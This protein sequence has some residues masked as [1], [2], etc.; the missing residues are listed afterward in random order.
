MKDRRY[1]PEG[2]RINTPENGYYTSSADGL[3]KART[4]G[5]ILEGTAL[6]CS[7]RDMSL[8]VD[9]GGSYGV[10]P[11]DEAGRGEGGIPVRDIAVITRVAHT[12]CFKVAALPGEA[13]PYAILSRRAAQDECEE[14]Y[15]SRLAPGD[16]IPAAVT[17][18]EPFGA[19][20]DVGC[21]VV[22]L[23]T[24]DTVSVSRIASPADRFSVGD[25]VSAVVRSRDPE[26]G[27]IFLTH[28]ELLGTWEENA[29]E[30]KPSATV[31]GIVRSVEDYG[32]FVEL[33]PNLAGLA[34]YKEGVAPGDPCAVFIK[35]I[36]PEKMKVKLV[37]V[38]C[39]GGE[40]RIPVRYYLDAENTRRID[41]WRYSPACC[42]RVIE[43]VFA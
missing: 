30:I 18:L 23:L 35:S 8:L 38:D 28:R 7:P 20:V 32:V 16:V 36:I 25:A 3:A 37:L 26:T 10:I 12:V 22:S 43:T 29:R 5:A 41:R 13:G 4:S 9:L 21:G 24:V 31:R 27:R 34:E 19:F 39:G 17:H 15:L 6:E 14:N 33:F 42:P 40:V 11:R 2:A 1:L